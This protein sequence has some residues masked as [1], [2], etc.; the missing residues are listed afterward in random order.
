[1][2][3]T[4][5]RE[6][7]RASLAAS[8]VETGLHYPV[9]LHLQPALKSLGYAAGDFP[10]AERWAEEL[11]SLP[12]FPELEPEEIELVGELVATAGTG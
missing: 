4:P 12:M 9:P 8:G 5:R 7:I 3:R 2:V 1:V 11:L 6:A 10:T